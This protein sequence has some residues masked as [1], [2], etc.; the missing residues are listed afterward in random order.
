METRVIYGILASLS[1]GSLV[2]LNKIVLAKGTNPFLINLLMGLG[3]VG[4]MAIVFLFAQPS[5]HMDSGS[6]MLSILAGIL[7]AVG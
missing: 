3:I 5:V 4:A 6:L 7:W 1:F 2:V